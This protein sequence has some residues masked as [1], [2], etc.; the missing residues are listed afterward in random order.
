MV[1]DIKLC[2]DCKWYKKN[3]F[4][5]LLGDTNND[6]CSHPLVSGDVINGKN[7][8]WCK[9]ARNCRCGYQGKFWEARK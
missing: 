5:H 3:W 4:S 6:N 2:K 8:L 1:N 7:L 9:T